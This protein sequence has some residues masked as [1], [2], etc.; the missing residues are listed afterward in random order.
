MKQLHPEVN[1]EYINT[2]ESITRRSVNTH[3]VHVIQ[4]EVENAV[5]YLQHP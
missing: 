2:M 4:I 5:T 3:T 1:N